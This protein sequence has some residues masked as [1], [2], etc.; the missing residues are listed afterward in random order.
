[1][2]QVDFGIVLMRTSAS[3]TVDVYLECGG[4]VAEVLNNSLSH[5]DEQ[6]PH[7]FSLVALGLGAIT[8]E[9]APLVKESSFHGLGH[10]L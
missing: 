3:C 10:G 5:S 1:M 8:I 7:R 6:E 4:I 2:D 9:S